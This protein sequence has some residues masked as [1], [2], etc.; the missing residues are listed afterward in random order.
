MD[1][2]DKQVMLTFALRWSSLWRVQCILDVI[3]SES[4]EQ[5]EKMEFEQ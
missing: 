2:K 3:L 1:V 5:T 4:T